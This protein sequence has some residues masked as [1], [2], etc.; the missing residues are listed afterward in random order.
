MNVI[1]QA[2]ARYGERQRERAA[3]ILE[4]EPDARRAVEAFLLSA[5]DAHLD[6]THPSGCMVVAGTGM[7]DSAVVP[8]SI[9]EAVRTALRA[10]AEAIQARLAR[11]VQ[12]RQLPAATDVVA[13][14]IYF[15][16]VLA[17]LSVQSKGQQCRT[18][19]REVV[20]SAMRS[21]PARAAR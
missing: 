6:T 13:L 1:L 10:G 11:A 12:E 8:D 16:T 17:G 14:A 20:A 7:C 3:A 9:K 5:V 21:W 4:S 19:L 18:V 2:L 15:N